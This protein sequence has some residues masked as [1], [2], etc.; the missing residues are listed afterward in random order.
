MTVLVNDEL[1]KFQCEALDDFEKLRIAMGNRLY[2]MTKTEAD[3]DGV[4]RG[5]G[6]SVDDPR[7]KDYAA[8]VDDLADME[9]DLIK[10]VQKTTKAGPFGPFIKDAKGVGE[11]QAARL[12]ACIGDPYWHVVEDR[13]RTVSELWAYCGMHVVEKEAP[14]RKKGVKSNWNSDARKRVWLIANSCI[15]TKGHYRDVYD[16]ARAHYSEAT[17]TK[18]CAQC[19]HAKPGSPLKDGH[20]HARAIRRV[21]KEVLKDLWLEAKALHLAAEKAAQKPS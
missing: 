12:L 4:V 21:S 9:M 2:I 17:H 6:L 7:V 3:E 14:R 11:K 16:A 19:G 1:A 13:P 5:F 18:E 20:K 15:K 8:I 10:G